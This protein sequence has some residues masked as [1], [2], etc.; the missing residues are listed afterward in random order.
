MRLYHFL[1]EE[2]A[3]DD[4]KRR[5]L[6]ISR[7]DEL[8]DPFELL[9]ADLGDKTTRRAFQTMRAE[10]AQQ[11][12]VLCFSRSWRS[13]V[14]WSHY[15]DRHRGI[16]LGFEVPTGKFATMNYDAKRLPDVLPKLLT[17]G[18]EAQEQAMLRLL[19]TKFSGWKYENEV[20]VFSSLETIDADTGY[21]FTDFNANLRLKTVILGPRCKHPVEEIAAQCRGRYPGVKIVAARLAFRSFRI[22]ERYGSAV[23]V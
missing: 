20:R 5:R 3:L 22:V 9:G 2:H 11:C 10:L 16:C 7:L 8:N 12:G 17:G 6:K 23:V 21:P 1:K 18:S 15:A 4:L 19:T 13:P 14:M